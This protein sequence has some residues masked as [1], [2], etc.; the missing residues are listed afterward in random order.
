MWLNVVLTQGSLPEVEDQVHDLLRVVDI[1]VPFA[2]RVAG[3]QYSRKLRFIEPLGVNG[4]RR[5]VPCAPSSGTPR[6]SQ[7]KF[8]DGSVWGL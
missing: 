6:E 1:V 2:P 7:A 8:R 4:H 5:P 3:C